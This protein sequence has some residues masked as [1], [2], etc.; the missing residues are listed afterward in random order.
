MKKEFDDEY[1]ER[2]AEF[3]RALGGTMRLKLLEIIGTKKVCVGEIMK[4]L[5]VPQ[6]NISQHLTILRNA[7]ILSK[8]REGRAVCYKIT[9]PKILDLVKSVDELLKK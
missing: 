4:Q 2:K 7:G 9:N 5:N 3:I 6:P 1:L 8:K